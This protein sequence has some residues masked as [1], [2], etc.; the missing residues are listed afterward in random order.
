MIKL[1]ASLFIISI[2]Y[3]AKADPSNRLFPAPTFEERAQMVVD[4]LQG[5]LV[6]YID[7]RY[8]IGNQEIAGEFAKDVYEACFKN[9]AANDWPSARKQFYCLIP[10]KFRACYTLRLI[11]E[12]R[13]LQQRI[14]DIYRCEHKS[15]S[16][17][18][19]TRDF[20]AVFRSL[21]LEDPDVTSLADADFEFAKVPEVSQSTFLEALQSTVN[22]VAYQRELAFCKKLKLCQ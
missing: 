15:Q 20:V 5:Q 11:D 19:T 10:F 22:R 16:E 1:L 3:T 12:D 17:L 7:E 21:V 18:T 4:K 13:T 9:P 14:A 2:S 6:S 8:D